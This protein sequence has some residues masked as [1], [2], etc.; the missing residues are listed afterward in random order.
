MQLYLFFFG[1][2]TPAQWK[3]N[4]DYGWD[5]ESSMA[6]YVRAES[7]EAAKLWGCEVA[8]KFCYQLFERTENWSGQI[9][10]WKQ[11]EFAFWIETS[12]EN[13]TEEFLER[14]HT[15]EYGEIPNFDDL[16][17]SDK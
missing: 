16:K 5:D 3:A 11:S 12:H 1:Y 17:N 4:D 9:P 2:C 14:L 13:L 8:E 15:V 10:S 7:E 6:F